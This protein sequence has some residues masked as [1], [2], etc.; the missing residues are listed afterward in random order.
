M[1]AVGE[2]LQINLV[3]AYLDSPVWADGCGH[4]QLRQAVRVDK[5]VRVTY[6]NV[7]LEIHSEVMQSALMQSGVMQSEVMRSEITQL[8]VMFSL[9]S[10]TKTTR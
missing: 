10:V 8:A 4:H 2:Y 5:L 3:H 7:E 1:T 6:K 9:C